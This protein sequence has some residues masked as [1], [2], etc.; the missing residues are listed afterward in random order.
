MSKAEFVVDKENL[1]VRLTRVFKAT[2]ERLW[3]AHT[4]PAQVV[5]WWEDTTIDKLEV[6]VGGAWRFVSKG[7]DGQEYARH[8]K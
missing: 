7:Q 2:P 6:S 8:A 1:E 4:D 3:Q 5:R